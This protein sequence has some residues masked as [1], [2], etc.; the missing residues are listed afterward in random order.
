MKK[1]SDWGLRTAWTISTALFVATTATSQKSAG[2]IEEETAGNNLSVPVVW[3]DRVALTLRG[4][5]DEL[6]VLLG[7]W[8]YWW[9]INPGDDTP[10]S[11]PPDPDDMTR[12]DDG[13]PGRATGP[14][15]GAYHPGNEVYQAFLQKDEFNVW[16]AWNDYAQG[17]VFVDWVDWGDNLEARN[18]NLRSQVRT[19]V[20]LLEDLRTD[21][22]VYGGWEPAGT[23]IQYSMLHTS[24]WG[25]TEMH[26]LAVMAGVPQVGLGEE[27]TVYS[28]SVRFVIQKMNIR[29][30]D[31]RTQ[32]LYWGG[33]A[34]WV[35]PAATAARLIEMPIY[36]GRVWQSGDGPGFYKAEINIKGRVIYGYTWNVRDMNQG[37]GDYRLTFALEQGPLAV[38]KNTFFHEDVTAIV[39]F[40]DE[41]STDGPKVGGGGGGGGSGGGQGGAPVG[42]RPKIDY[43]HQ[44]TY[45]DV[46]ITASGR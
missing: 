22:S 10:L 44:L 29:R 27:A 32:H 18:W 17:P 39:P 6:P 25:A 9:G 35:E 31:P 26:G 43:K 28:H 30:D 42:A 19:E 3:S 41:E 13:V 16:Q 33:D 2:R 36:D 45:I 4:S 21:D 5:P 40:G 14:R 34:G 37:A 12:C 23:P 24:G 15:P 11:C 46:R 8:W 7:D 38:R 20:V 1:L